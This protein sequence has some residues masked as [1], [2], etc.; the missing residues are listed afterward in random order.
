[1]A[2]TPVT[3]ILESMTVKPVIVPVQPKAKVG[4]TRFVS[5]DLFRKGLGVG[6][7]A[8]KRGMTVS[9][10]ETHLA[11]FMESGEIKVY[12]LVSDET[13]E[14]IVAA[15]NKN[16]GQGLATIKQTLEPS[17]TYNQLRIVRQYLD[18]LR[19]QATITP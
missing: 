3:Q 13:V 16:P 12:D 15:F 19:K 11:S 2:R 17:I 1:L 10:I 18:L 9:T 5:L 14:L 4:E 6:E 8:G 7:I